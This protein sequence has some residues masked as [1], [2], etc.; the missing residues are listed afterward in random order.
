MKKLW[1]IL[2]L[3]LASV[4]ISLAEIPLEMAPY[5]MS[6]ESGVYSTG[7][8]WGDIDKNGFL[9]F[10]ISNGNDMALAP[11]YVYFNA[12]GNLQTTHGWASSN[13]QYSGHSALGD[14][15]NDGYL[16]FA[17]SN[18]TANG[19]ERTTVQLYMNLGGSLETSPSWESADSMHT[20]ACAF[21][22]ADGDGD[23][24]LAVACGEAYTSQHENQRIYY[25][26]GGTLETTPSWMSV[27]SIPCYDVEWGDVDNDG[28]LDLAFTSAIGPVYVYYNYG[29]SIEHS[30]SWTSTNSYSGNTLNWGDMD[31]D[32]YL[33][34][35]V[36]NNHQLA[37]EG[38]FQVYRNLGGTLSSTWFWRSSNGGYGSSVS[39]CDVDYDGDKDLAAGRWWGYSMIYEN[40]GGTLTTYPV[41]Q[42]STNYRSVV[43]EMV[44]GDVDGDG[45]LIVTGETHPGDGLK[46]VFYLNHYPAHSLENVIADGD[47]LS[48][49][50]YCYNLA[51]GWISVASAPLSQIAFDYHYSYKPDLGVSNWGESNYV[52][53]NIAPVPYVWGDANG[54]D[55]VNSADVVFLINYLFKGGPPPI[56][57][58][59]GDPNNDCVINSA[60][61]VYLINYLFKGGPAPQQGCA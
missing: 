48:L 49:N 17:V 16:D 34:L 41:W 23:L 24:D 2:L 59:S 33:D 35:A 54:D 18:Y 30:A 1:L 55:V 28:D 60:D 61:V 25:N 6:T 50:E 26:S 42:C 51:S 8:N 5:W 13:S 38:Y 9:D 52:F 7:A 56:P 39:W 21:G 46:K 44:W 37:P 57:L 43:E 19:W 11:N 27:D 32:G 4:E 36:A 12:G 10:A 20:F 47:T 3:F 15:N 45:V 31:N 29:D 40:V 58:P 53:R 14:V 22:D